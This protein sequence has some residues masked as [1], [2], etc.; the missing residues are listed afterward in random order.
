MIRPTLTVSAANAPHGWKERTAARRHPHPHKLA[1]VAWTFSFPLMSG[2]DL[3]LLLLRQLGFDRRQW[4]NASSLVKPGNYELR[5][6]S[7]EAKLRTIKSRL[8]RRIC[9]HV[10]QHTDYSV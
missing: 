10:Y 8:A 4:R 1:C 2:L 3:F 6:G 5:Q 9:W 7:L